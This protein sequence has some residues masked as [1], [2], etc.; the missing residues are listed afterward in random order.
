MLYKQECY[1]NKSE[2]LF[3][4]SNP[5]LVYTPY[6]NREELFKVVDKNN[7]R[8]EFMASFYCP[9]TSTYLTFAKYRLNRFD[10]L[11]EAITSLS[12]K[13]GFCFKDTEKYFAEQYSFNFLHSYTYH[14]FVS[15]HLRDMGINY[16]VVFADTCKITDKPRTRCDVFHLSNKNITWCFESEYNKQH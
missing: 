2:F 1:K 6:E 15:N 16:K 14:G 13:L 5:E 7:H 3:H 12:K 11:F 4:Q 8:A 10:S 9:E